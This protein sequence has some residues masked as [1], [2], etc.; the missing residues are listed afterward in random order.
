MSRF[1]AGQFRDALLRQTV[2]LTQFVELRIPGAPQY[3][4]PH[5]VDFAWNNHVW[6]GLG[7]LGGI[8][9]VRETP[10]Q[11][12]GIELRLSGVIE[13]N[14]AEVLDPSIRGSE[15]IV[16]LVALT[17]EQKIVPNPIVSWIGFVDRPLISIDSGVATITLAC[18]H[19]SLRNKL[20]RTYRYTHEDQQIL[21]P[22]DVN[23]E[24]D[25][26]FEYVT[27]MVERTVVWPQKSFFE[28]Q[29]RAGG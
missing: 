21:Y 24:E 29:I 8:S 17:A 20:P 15:V 26:G 6:R 1:G 19:I 23:N 7:G 4:N 5:A 27:Q 28:K 16:Y 12:S 14:V 2:H 25:R 3:L 13:A 22:S 9:P 11:I 10:G 18:E